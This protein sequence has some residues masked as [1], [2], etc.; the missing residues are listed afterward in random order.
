M[1]DKEKAI[2]ILVEAGLSRDYAEIAITLTPSLE[3][4]KIDTI[5]DNPEGTKRFIKAE[6]EC[7]GSVPL[8]N[9]SM[10]LLP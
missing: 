4:D 8:G 5:L 7:L 2:N 10:F 3:Q 1:T 9:L 6:F